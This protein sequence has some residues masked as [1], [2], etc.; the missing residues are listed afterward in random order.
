MS[1]WKLSERKR[2]KPYWLYIISVI[3]SSMLI[4]C[5]V[6]PALQYR[7]PQAQFLSGNN[8]RALMM[9][10]KNIKAEYRDNTKSI[11]RADFSDS[12][13]VES[14]NSFIIFGLSKSFQVIPWTGPDSPDSSAPQPP[15]YSRLNADTGNLEATAAY[16]Q[17]LAAQG[18]V[19]IVVIPYLCEL[20][21]FVFQPEGW[22]G[23]YD[24]S[25][26]KP[27]TYSAQTIVVLQLWSKNGVLLVERKAAT[28]TGRP[29]LYSILKQE[30]PKK[31]LVVYAKNIY[32]PPLVKSMYNAVMSALQ[33]L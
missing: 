23:K 33:G 4:S 13:L 25:Y 5:A 17:N 19:D 18:K 12:F 28:D 7:N 31:D 2:M 21:Y 24:N 32:A 15:V 29:L 22:R 1:D 9:P 20:K 26:A 27:A 8:S 6:Q 16:V 3:A 14:V 11:P 30:K 10:V